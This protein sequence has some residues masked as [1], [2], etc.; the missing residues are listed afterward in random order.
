MKKIAFIV[1]VILIPLLIA[2]CWNY[3][4]IDTFAI[5]AGI[6]MDKGTNGDKYHLTFE[7][8]DTS[9]GSVSRTESAVKSLLVESDGK[10]IFDAGRNTMT[11]SDKKLYYGSCRVVIISDELAREGVAALLDWLNRDAE[12]RATINLFIARGTKAK[13]VIE[14]GTLSN[15]ITSYA[16]D[17]II[18]NNPQFL[19]KAPA[20]QLYKANN[21]LGGE[22]ISLTL[23][24]LDIVNNANKQ[25]PAIGGTAIF[26]KDKL[27]GYLDNDE[28][29]Y[30]VLLKDEGAGGLLPISI[31]SDEPN[32]TLEIFYSQ[33]SITTDTKG[34]SPKIK[35][36]VSARSAFAEIETSKG[37]LSPDDFKKA[38]SVAE[39]TIASN[40]QNLIRKVQTE[41]G[42]DIFGFGNAIYRD[43]PKYW[44][45]IKPQWDT[46]FASLQVDVSV[47]VV[48]ANS[49]QTIKGV[50]VGD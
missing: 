45:K 36:A 21:M 24:L 22:G 20:V 27:L 43:A 7:T 38:K 18:R 32:A 31:D 44:E 49:A 23:P 8:V 6:A 9:G 25:I 15:P 17:K 14:K 35:I 4:E 42:S 29:W 30:F 13:E 41:Y 26:K 39:Q 28:S 1:T 5:V 47:D 11:R 34:E 16:I 40:I 33:A 2:G 10:T 46:L 12:P 19:S 3:K 37:T 50:Q 48:I